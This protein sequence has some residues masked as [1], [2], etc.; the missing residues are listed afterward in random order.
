MLLSNHTNMTTNTSLFNDNELSQS[1]IESQLA[2]L[3]KEEKY[4]QTILEIKIRKELMTHLERDQ[5][6]EFIKNTSAMNN[7]LNSQEIDDRNMTTTHLLFHKITNE[8]PICDKNTIN[9]LILSSGNERTLN[10]SF[11][12]S[13]I[14]KFQNKE[15]IKTKPNVVITNI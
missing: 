8:C 6:V 14:P 2:R 1:N 13:S 7:S 9:G 12:S 4:L 5:E 10:K 15:E 11:T 3:K